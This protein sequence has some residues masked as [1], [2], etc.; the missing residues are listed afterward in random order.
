MQAGCAGI[1]F[2]GCRAGL[3]RGHPQIEQAEDF[4]L[5]ETRAGRGSGDGE[6][7]LKEFPFFLQHLIDVFFD[8][9]DGHHASDGYRAAGTDAMRAVD[10]LIFDGR[11]PPAVKQKHIATELQ[12]Q[13]D[14]SGTV[15]H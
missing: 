3:A 11:I 12:V 9:V 6:N 13:T 7:G 5:V 15:A 1:D 10:C 8:G 14:T 2:L 4:V